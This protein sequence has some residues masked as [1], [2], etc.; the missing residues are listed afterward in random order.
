MKVGIVVDDYKL[1][2]FRE[3]LNKK[4]FVFTDKPFTKDVTAIFLHIQPSQLNEVKKICVEQ[5]INFNQAN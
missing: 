1:P 3:A 5:Q 4:G 2:K